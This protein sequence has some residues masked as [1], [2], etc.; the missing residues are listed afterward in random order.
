MQELEEVVG[1]GEHQD[2]EVGAV[3]HCEN[4]QEGQCEVVFVEEIHEE[5]GLPFE[6]NLD[7]LDEGV[8]FQQLEADL[9]DSC[10]GQILGVEGELLGLINVLLIEKDSEEPLNPIGLCGNHESRLPKL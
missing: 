5:G 1:E 4:H 7:F 2:Y 9:P 3:G 10:G 6:D 8:R